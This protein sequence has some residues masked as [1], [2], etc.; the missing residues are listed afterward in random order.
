[1]T[2]TIS[3]LQKGDENPKR[4]TRSLVGD[5]FDSKSLLPIRGKEP[6]KKRYPRSSQAQGLELREGEEGKSE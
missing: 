3:S 1:M 5:A 4:F 2:I 6:T